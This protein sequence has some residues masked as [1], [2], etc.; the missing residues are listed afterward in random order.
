MTALGSRAGASLARCTWGT[1]GSRLGEGTRPAVAHTDRSQSSTAAKQASATLR[2]QAIP[3][4]LLLTSLA[5][6]NT[7]AQFPT[8]RSTATFPFQ[9]SFAALTI[10]LRRQPTRVCIDMHG[11][12]H[13]I[14]PFGNHQS[15]AYCLIC[16]GFQYCPPASWDAPSYLAGDEPTR[17]SACILSGVPC[18]SNDCGILG[19][20]FLST[21]SCQCDCILARHSCSSASP[22]V[23]G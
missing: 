6:Q 18:P 16:E 2:A 23:L 12:P 21:P 3:Q 22:H 13:P 5:S 17:S 11:D 9:A 15:R 14:P 19:R 8:S 10:R 4:R 1:S 7:P 20:F